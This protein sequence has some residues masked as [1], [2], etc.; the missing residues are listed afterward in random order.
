MLLYA[1]IPWLP[2]N[3]CKQVSSIW[4]LYT[5]SGGGSR[6]DRADSQYIARMTKHRNLLCFVLIL[7][8]FYDIEG[9]FY[10]VS[11]LLYAVIARLPTSECKQ[12][13]SIWLLFVLNVF[14]ILTDV[15]WCYLKWYVVKH[16]NLR[17]IL[18]NVMWN[19]APRESGGHPWPGMGWEW[20]YSTP[21]KLHRNIIQQHRNII[22]FIHKAS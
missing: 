8:C 13:R 17:C 10:A 1:V 19:L 6:G 11:M 9:C 20:H 14:W 7:W 16:R 15:I 4:L 3:R 2:T 12:M 21:W 22:G 5:L 18:I